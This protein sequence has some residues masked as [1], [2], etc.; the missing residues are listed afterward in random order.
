MECLTQIKLLGI[1]E[2]YINIY[3]ILY[4]CCNCY[5]SS[6]SLYNVFTFY[7][8]KSDHYNRRIKMLGEI[9][10]NQFL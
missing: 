3:T 7:S 6:I 5:P 10:K 1:A 8:K 9:L 4:F 2:R